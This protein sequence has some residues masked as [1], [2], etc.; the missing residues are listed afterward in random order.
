MLQI[1]TTCMKINLKDWFPF[2][3]NMIVGSSDPHSFR[4]VPKALAKVKAIII[5]RQFH[6]YS[7]KLVGINSVS[8]FCRKP[9]IPE[10]HDSRILFT[11][12]W[13]PVLTKTSTPKIN[14]KRRNAFL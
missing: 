1:L 13:K 8:A 7:K 2:D 14:V 12:I 3:R 11:M 4:L 5:P 6:V 9:N 10:S